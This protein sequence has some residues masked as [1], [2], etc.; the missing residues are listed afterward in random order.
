MGGVDVC[1][2]LLSSYRPRLR[3][4]KWWWNL[5]SN[6]LNLS[7]VASFRF[8]NFVN[9]TDVTHLKFRREIATSLIKSEK[10][11]V[12]LGGPSAQPNPSVRFNGV[13][14]ILNATS[15]GR[16]V[17]CQKNTRLARQKCGKRLHKA[18]SR[19]YHKQ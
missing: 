2:C 8:H 15:Q 16:C 12:C 6:L 10:A 14:H 18:C 4:K 1:D 3:S 11:R 9:Q 13:N 5:F 19:D 17:Y 7:V